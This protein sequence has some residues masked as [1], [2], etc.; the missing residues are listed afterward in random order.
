M[1]DE[2]KMVPMD[3]V[4]KMIQEGIKQALE[5]E[6]SRAKA[7]QEAFLQERRE[8]KVDYAKLMKSSNM[9]W[10]NIES[11]SE[12]TDQ[13]IPIEMEW[14]ESMVRYLKANGVPGLTEEEIIQT[15]LNGIYHDM[16][17]PPAGDGED[18]AVKGDFA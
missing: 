11:G 2:N 1:S 9:P 17:P 5:D 12:I 4:Q 10:V 15:W 6:R 13:G 14:N 3:Q 7:E 18:E 8:K 16:T